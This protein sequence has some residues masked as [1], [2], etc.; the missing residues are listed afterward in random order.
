M[1]VYLK[2]NRRTC[3]NDRIADLLSGTRFKNL[4]LTLCLYCQ[5]ERQKE[6]QSSS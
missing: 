4:Y 1:Q 3:K 5:Y 2:R 6:K